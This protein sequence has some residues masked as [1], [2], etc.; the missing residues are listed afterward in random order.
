VWIRCR[1]RR[2]TAS[3]PDASAFGRGS[4]PSVLRNPY[5]S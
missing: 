4:A 1:Y 3:K 2:S 5:R